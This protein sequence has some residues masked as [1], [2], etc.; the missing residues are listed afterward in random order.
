MWPHTLE[1]VDILQALE[2]FSCVYLMIS[3][4]KDIKLCV[5]SRAILSMT[6]LRNCETGNYFWSLSRAY[7]V[8]EMYSL[9]TGDYYINSENQLIQVL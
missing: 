9:K 7:I 2:K 1:A 4:N 8:Y 3:E 6:N 5:S